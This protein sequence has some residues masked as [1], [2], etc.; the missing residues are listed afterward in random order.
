MRGAGPESGGAEEEKDEAKDELP[1]EEVVVTRDPFTHAKPYV[2][3]GCLPCYKPHLW[4]PNRR[5]P[6]PKAKSW[7]ER[8]WEES[9]WFESAAP[10]TTTRALSTEF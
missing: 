4:N 6:S 3:D 8:W 2:Y 9:W 7:W 10:P 1:V 5:P